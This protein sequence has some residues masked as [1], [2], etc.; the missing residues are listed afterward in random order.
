MLLRGIVRQPKYI[1]FNVDVIS[2][3]LKVSAE[4][5]IQSDETSKVDKEK[6]DE[7][8]ELI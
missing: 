6:L 3:M 4:N 1:N 5:E 7:Y 8:K 2:K